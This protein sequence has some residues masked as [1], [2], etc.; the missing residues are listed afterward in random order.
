MKSDIVLPAQKTIYSQRVAQVI[1]RII[2]VIPA[3]V[4]VAQFCATT[5]IACNEMQD[6][7]VHPDS[8]LIAVL[9]AARVGLTPGSALG[10]AYFVPRKGKCN[11]EVGYRGY[12]DL[13]FGNKHLKNVHAE[14]VLEG[15]PFN[16]KVTETGPKVEHELSLSRDVTTG[17]CRKNCVGAYCV[18]ETAAGGVGVRVVTRKQLNGVDSNRHVWNSD[19]YEMARKTAIRRAAKDWKITAELG[20]ALHLDQQSDLGKEQQPLVEGLELSLPLDDEV[21]SLASIPDDGPTEY[22]DLLKNN[23]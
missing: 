22:D 17:S 19:Y 11:L 8:V 15:E 7:S 2:P 23:D 4:N 9:N 5:I 10:L 14:V 12:L 6:G 16:W 13:A 18:Y 20:Y 3:S 1:D 21:V